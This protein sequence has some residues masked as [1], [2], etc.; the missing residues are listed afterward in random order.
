[1][2]ERGISGPKQLLVNCLESS[3]DKAGLLLKGEIW[4]I[5]IGVLARAFGLI[6]DP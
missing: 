2:V 1:M 3:T 6:P 4:G 5:L